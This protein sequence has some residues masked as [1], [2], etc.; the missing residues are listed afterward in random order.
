MRKAG[1]TR[2]EFL[3]G[4]GL[5]AGSLLLGGCLGSAK[6]QTPAKDRPNILWIT[7]EDISP[8]L[9]CYGDALADTPNLDRL[10]ADGVRDY[11]MKF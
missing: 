9:R 5:F 10:A 7:C 2:R 8:W 3:A 1:N 6:R 4:S 11:L